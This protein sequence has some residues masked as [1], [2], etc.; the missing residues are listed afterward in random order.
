MHKARNRQIPTLPALADHFIWSSSAPQSSNPSVQ[1]RSTNDFLAEKQK[2]IHQ[3]RKPVHLSQIHFS[4]PPLHLTSQ[5]S[6]QNRPKA[7]Q[8]YWTEREIVT[9]P[10]TKRVTTKL[11]GNVGKG[12]K[13]DCLAVERLSIENGKPVVLLRKQH[14]SMLLR[15]LRGRNTASTERL[16]GVKRPKEE[17]QQLRKSIGLAKGRI[18]LN[19]SPSLPIFPLIA[20][21]IAHF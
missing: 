9:E 17:I 12:V 15:H 8:Y 14:F 4:S 21:K 7:L 19:P 6:T 11:R 18:S 2:Y 5:R 13:R 3:I 20:V 10:L 16:K 1:P